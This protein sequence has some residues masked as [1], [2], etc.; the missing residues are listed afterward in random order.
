LKK[1]FRGSNFVQKFGPSYKKRR[2]SGNISEITFKLDE[3]ANQDITKAITFHNG[4]MDK[5]HTELLPMGNAP[6]FENTAFYPKDYDFPEK[7]WC[8]RRSKIL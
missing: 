5:L 6:V 3:R 8:F 1:L 2:Q 7:V 4:R